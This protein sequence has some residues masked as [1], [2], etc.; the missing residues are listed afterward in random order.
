MCQFLRLIAQTKASTKTFIANQR[1]K[2]KD[3]FLVQNLHTTYPATSPGGY[4]NQQGP[5]VATEPTSGV[6][7][8][9]RMMI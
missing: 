2:L 1:K 5:E 7:V 3:C 8:D 6:G 4:N 9:G